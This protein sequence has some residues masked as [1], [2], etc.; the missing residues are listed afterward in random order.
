MSSDELNESSFLPTC[1]LAELQRQGR[2][3]LTIEDRQLLL[4]WTDKGVVALDPQ[5]P[6]QHVQSLDRGT[7]ACGEITCPNH[8]WTFSLRTGRARIGSGRI[9]LYPTRITDETIEV[10]IPK[11]RPQWMQ[12]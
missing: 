9:K 1:T 7:V 6:H 2:M 10:A 11:Q 4:I 5:C 12:D 3:V 8:G